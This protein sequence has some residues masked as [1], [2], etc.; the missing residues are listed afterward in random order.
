MGVNG[1]F[2]QDMLL[3]MYLVQWKEKIY[4]FALALW[5]LNNSGVLEIVFSDETCLKQ[6]ENG[7]Q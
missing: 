4:D 2:G 6:T 7:A 5:I 1:Q 3:Q